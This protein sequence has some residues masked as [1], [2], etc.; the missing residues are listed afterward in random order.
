M[1]LCHD[2]DLTEEDGKKLGFQVVSLEDL[3]LQ[4][5]TVSCH[6]QND[7]KMEL[8]IQ[9]EHFQSMP[10]Y[11]T[12]INTS[13]GSSIEEDSMIEVLRWRRDLTACL[14]ITNPSPP[15]QEFCSFCPSKCCP[16]SQSFW[17]CK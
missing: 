15:R 16:Y 6:I 11:A 3:F 9:K 14:D 5:H 10:Q 12:F 1:F 2:P 8:K 13:S 7:S 17:I 4:S